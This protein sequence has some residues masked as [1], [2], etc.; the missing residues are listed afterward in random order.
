MK[1]SGTCLV[2]TE[3]PGL[4]PSGGIGTHV[5]TLAALFRGKSNLVILHAGACPAKIRYL[6]INETVTLVNLNSVSKRLFTG[7]TS[8]QYSQS[9][10]ALDWLK[11]NNFSHINFP[12]WNAL[13]FACIA[14]KK[15]NQ[16]FRDTTL[17]VTMHGMTAWAKSGNISGPEEKQGFE[18]GLIEDLEKFTLQNCDLLIS[19]S[20][21]LGKW[22]QDNLDID[23]EF[24]VICNPY[25][26]KNVSQ[27]NSQNKVS[28]TKNISF[29][30]RVENRKGIQQF[31]EAIDLINPSN[32]VVN[33]VGRN[34]LGKEFFQPFGDKDWFKNLKH[35][36]NM[37]SS[38]ALS[39]F[40][41]TNSLVVVPSKIENCPYVVQELCDYQLR[42]MC[43]SVGGIPE[44]IGLESRYQGSVEELAG[45][46]L[47]FINDP[48]SIPRAVP[49]Q[50]A[51]ENNDKWV[52]VLDSNSFGVRNS[53]IQSAGL[54]SEIGVVIPHFNQS[55][56]LRATLNSLLRQS[57]Q[58]FK[59]IVIDDGSDWHNLKEFRRIA[60]EFEQDRFV[61]HEQSNED[62]GRTRN[63]GAELLDTDVITFLDSDD[64]LEEDFLERLSRIDFGLNIIVS[65]HFSIFSDNTNNSWDVSNLIGS[66]EPVG[67]ISSKSWYRNFLGGANFAI[68]RQLF[69]ELGGFTVERRQNH[70]DWRFLVKAQS[71]GI[72]ILSL[73]YRLLNYRVMQESMTRTRSHLKGH[74]SVVD[75][76]VESSDIENLRSVTKELMESHVLGINQNMDFQ[77]ISATERLVRKIQRLAL[78]ITP[79]GSRRWRVAL[80]IYR[81]IAK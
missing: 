66:Y 12:D 29:F 71:V 59:C 36:D 7:G 65:S 74:L 61:F 56:Y 20:K 6:K 28:K 15:L 8:P 52:E 45:K 10:L 25:L 64:V 19:P 43:N 30:G 78:R 22:S 73:P 14:A 48:T 57:F 77:F 63:L 9:L 26:S 62:V 53:G 32:M 68:R 54:N 3:Y 27:E 75:E 72:E 40:K 33:I 35:L 37:T 13:G 46:I 42:V 21:Y 76:Y 47:N 55:K 79:Y 67:S 69:L 39:F 23:R 34:T 4:G 24:I 2:T 31:L 11:E 80:V 18:F 44:L 49:L 58:G 41:E 17:S 1:F 70:Q 5:E 60:Q 81:K 51:I 38:E 50:N 16:D